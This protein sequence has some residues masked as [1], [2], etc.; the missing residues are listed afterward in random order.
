MILAADNINPMNPAV[1]DAME[2]LDPKPI[3]DI[4]RQC[5][6]RGVHYIDINPGY[7]GKRKHDRMT[8]LIE[9]V[10]EATDLKLI[11]DSPNPEL[12]KMG[13]KSCKEKPILNALTKEEI[14]LKEIL[15][16]A[17]EEEIELIFLLLDENSMAPP[18]HDG[19]ISLAM[20]LWQ[21]AT[22]KGFDEEKIIFDSVMPNIAWH[23]AFGQVGEC[24]KTIRMLSS[25]IVLGKPARTMIGV[26]NLLSGQEQKGRASLDETCLAVLSGAGLDIALVN[27]AREGLMSAYQLI[28]KMG[29]NE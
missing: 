9:A 25:G 8:F 7:L 5:K 14:K 1:I 24:V 19:K 4:A 10:Q 15:P 6:K 12:L 26:S 22:S 28:S 27:V 20:E 18:N 17:I 16:L 23:D 21:H 3:Q 29:L 2:R 13:L 11:L